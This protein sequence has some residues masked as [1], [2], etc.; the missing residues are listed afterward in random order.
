MT[1]E[2]KV[3][4]PNLELTKNFKYEPE[5]RRE[6]ATVSSV[7]PYILVPH[8]PRREPLVPFLPFPRATDL[9]TKA[10]VF[11]PELES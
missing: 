4:K 3:S 6:H 1:V 7:R 9:S 8:I 11:C 10:H 5:T 2:V